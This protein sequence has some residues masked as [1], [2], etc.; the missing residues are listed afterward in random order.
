MPV[1]AI[2]EA[3]EV[4]MRNINP[5]SW[6]VLLLAVL[7]A[8]G[9]GDAP[10]GG[11]TPSTHTIG[12]S[13]AGLSGTLVLQVN[14]GNSLSVTS[15]GI[16]T[17]SAAV[18]SGTAYAVTVLTQPAG[19]ICTVTGGS[20]AA[21]SSVTTVM[22]TC[23]WQVAAALPVLRINTTG[24]VAITSKEVYVTGTFQL[25]DVAGAPQGSG[26]L[27]VRGRG[28]ST[29]N[30][31]KKPYRMKLAASTALLGM[32]ANRHWVLLANYLDKTLVRNEVAFEFSRRVG[33]AWTPRSEQV[34]LELN[35]E[36][37][38]VY[39]L[40]E[41][42]RI[43]N[44]RVNIPELRMADTAAD[45]ITGGYLLEVDFRQGE[46]YCRQT[47][48]GTWLCLANPETLLEPDWAQHKAYIDGYIDATVNALYGAQFADPLLGYA[49]YID[50]D[51]AV[52]FYLVQELL[53]NPD[54]NF[55]ASVFLYKPRGGKLF[56]GP[57]W[58]F[59]LA[60]NNAQW[61]FS[62]GSSPTGWHVRMQDSRQTGNYNWYTRLFQDPAFNQRVRTR[63]AEL[64]Q[65]GAIDS[66]LTYIDRREA[67]LSQVQ[68]QNFQR[69]NILNTVLPPQL[70]PVVGP[71]T[72]HVAAMRNFLQQR[73]IWMD[74]Q[75]L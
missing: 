25:L 48:N 30:Y 21:N 57:V 73:I 16:F 34:L 51:S 70:S 10:T 38:G 8:C 59:D 4:K 62:G 7:A 20:G 2:S 68:V 54:A 11:F 3:G 75:L 36:Y 71:Y 42:V 15:N 5:R 46:D 49:A 43:G 19:Q 69:W 18:T 45:L 24:G 44:E 35:G 39:M 6:L 37:L 61:S 29:W 67:W 47:S 17:F 56:L 31:P 33:M 13:I 41:H 1:A 65:A 27:E 28:N 53:K 50:V 74:S 23:A 9:G 66:L 32:P 64:R 26:N 55:L 58:D 14:G 40:T 63:W 22:V 52:N 60:I 72:L 12:G